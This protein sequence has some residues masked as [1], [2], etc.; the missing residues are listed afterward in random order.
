MQNVPRRCDNDAHPERLSTLI[1]R[2]DLPSLVEQYAGP[3]K[4]QGNTFTFSCPNPSHPDRNPSFTVKPDKNGK[5]RARCWSACA[6]QGDALNLVEWLEGLSIGEAVARL[7]HLLGDYVPATYRPG[8]INPKRV[9]PLE[10]SALI[11]PEDISRPLEGDR[12]AAIMSRYLTS[13]AWGIE[14]VMLFNLEVRQY[15][16][17][18][19]RIRHPFY[20]V[21]PTG[22]WL[23]TYWQDRAAFPC[24][25][26]ARWRSPANGVPTLFN[27]P[28]LENKKLNSVVIC[29]GP[30]D[31][32]SAAL[33]LH[34]SHMAA[35]GVPGV[36]AWRSEYAPLFD[37][38][39]VVVA[40]DNDEGGRTL[41]RNIAKD[42]TRC[43]VSFVRVSDGDLTKCV[44]RARATSLEALQELAKTFLTAGQVPT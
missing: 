16:N 33:L 43:R 8:P 25:P 2:V 11:T 20:S 32:I 12:A 38:L 7:R 24:P 22:E 4:R 44:E 28:A 40:A 3:G 21:S 31:T 14:A 9:S 27:L 19:P 1:E 35:I 6:W 10:A 23:L 34:G 42:L 37:G 29:E 17:N 26:K 36:G 39:N 41:E 13:R 18:E 5:W 15:P 30:A